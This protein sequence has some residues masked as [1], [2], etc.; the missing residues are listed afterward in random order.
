LLIF[1]RLIVDKQ[2]TLAQ[3]SVAQTAPRQSANSWLPAAAKSPAMPPP[4]EIAPI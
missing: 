2:R 3:S 1:P 4:I